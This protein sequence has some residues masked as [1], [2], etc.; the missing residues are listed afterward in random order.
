MNDREL[1]RNQEAQSSNRDLL[2]NQSHHHRDIKTI[3]PKE[4]SPSMS[5]TVVQESEFHEGDQ[6]TLPRKLK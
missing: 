3:A 4:R 2:L 5:R 1:L 6:F